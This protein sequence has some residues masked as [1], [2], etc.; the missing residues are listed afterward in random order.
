M[1]REEERD[2]VIVD[3]EA[4]LESLTSYLD[5]E[6]EKRSQNIVTQCKILYNAPSTYITCVPVILCQYININIITY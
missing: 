3:E 1:R 2:K 4:M 5:K 6:P